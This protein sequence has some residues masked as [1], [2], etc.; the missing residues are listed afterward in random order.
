M[1]SIEHDRCSSKKKL[2]PL[3]VSTS[4]VPEIDPTDE[5]LTSLGLGSEQFRFLFDKLPI[6][7]ALHKLKFNK[8]NVPVDFVTLAFNGAYEKLQNENL[9]F[10]KF[11]IVNRNAHDFYPNITLEKTDWSDIIVKVAQNGNTKQFEISDKCSYFNVTLCSP[12]KGYCF[13]SFMDITTKKLEFD[14]KLSRQQ[15]IEAILQG[16]LE[17]Y[18]KLLKQCP[19]AICE[20]DYETL[21]F[22]SAN[23]AMTKILGY[24]EP[25]LLTLSLFDLLYPDSIM[26]FQEEIAR[27]TDR[28]KIVES[29]EFHCKTKDDRGIY[30]VLD[31]QV[32][33]RLNK[34]VDVLLA[35]HDITERKK[36]Q[37]HLMLAEK[38][39]RRLYE[40]TQDGI[41]ARDL[42]GK[43]IAC[44]SAYAEML[45]YTRKELKKIS[46]KQLLLP[47]WREQREQIIQKVLQ[48]GRS[49]VF[50][51]E[52]LRKDGSTFPASVRTWRLTDGKGK[53][54]GL[55]SIVRDIS[56][57]KR[58]QHNLEMHA[59]NL[60][61]IVA[62]RTKQLKDSE[63]LIAIGQTA[64]MVG[65]DLRNPLQTLTGELYLAKAEVDTLSDGQ[66]KDSLQESITVIEDQVVYMDKIVSDLQAFVQP[67]QIDKKPIDIYSLAKE[68]LTS[69]A[70]PPNISVSMDCPEGFPAVKADPHL[71][72][73][74]L[75]NL[76]TNAVQ[77]MPDGGNLSLKMSF[78]G[79]RR[80]SL[81]VCDTGV[82]ISEGIKSQ[83][84]TPLF[85][86]KPRGQGFG[87]AVCKRV[88]EAHGGAIRFESNAGKGTKFTIQFPVD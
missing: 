64:G 58:L 30:C 34:P 33:N 37:H 78:N 29:Q 86:T 24:S 53:V 84:F 21:R 77:A 73:R 49:I 27:V 46:V 40:T 9:M 72:K 52:Y 59:D 70:I 45:G 75:I 71:L 2:T 35:V 3:K 39:F 68:V 80:I 56:E 88:M 51:R 7:V 16:G 67:I 87:L 1:T 47:K 48:T 83:I 41:M 54:V 79:T 8:S 5:L 28:K 42:H 32:I 60:E 57:Q 66:V 10:K 65:H 22:K 31:I 13:T 38:R 23:I 14:N 26:H 20:V 12:K 81:T 25:E 6:A 61:K 19:V 43:M 17:R 36:T 69:I 18:R 85:T 82:G 50:E 11:Q 62:E 74:V 4:T 76:V 15:K 44:N 55:W 63:R